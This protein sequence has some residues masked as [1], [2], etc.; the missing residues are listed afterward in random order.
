MV[1]KDSDAKMQKGKKTKKK[2]KNAKPCVYMLLFLQTI[3]ANYY[4]LVITEQN[5]NRF[6][7]N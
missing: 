3:Q 4:S 6:K 1:K 7:L 2:T 5:R